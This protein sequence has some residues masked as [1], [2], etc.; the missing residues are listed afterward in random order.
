MNIP[1]FQQYTIFNPFD[2]VVRI[3]NTDIDTYDLQQYAINVV[4]ALTQSTHTN[5]EYEV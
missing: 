5:H 4:M 1:W 2:A 3:Q